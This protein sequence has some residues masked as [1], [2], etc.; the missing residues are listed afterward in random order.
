MPAG[1]STNSPEHIKTGW[2]SPKYHGQDIEH[3]TR[4]L[5]GAWVEF[6][7]GA[8]VK[9]VSLVSDYSAVRI[10]NLPSRSS[11]ASVQKLLADVGITIPTSNINFIQPEKVSKAM[12]IVK[13]KDPEF[14]KSACWKLQTCVHA[15]N[16]QVNPI[17]VPLPVGSSFGLVDSKNVR[18]SWH[19]PTVNVTLYFVD[20]TTALESF[21]TCKN[22]GFK[23][24]GLPVKTYA[25][26][27]AD[28]SHEDRE[29]K[30]DLEGLVDTITVEDITN[31]FSPSH[32]PLY[33]DM[34]DPSYE[35]DLDM[36]STV[37]QSLLYEVGALERWAVFGNP[38]ARRVKAQAR[39]VQE[40]EALDAVSRLNEITLPFNP[41]G[42]L[43]LH[44]V[45]LVKFR[46]STWVYNVVEESIESHKE[47]WERKF[48]TFSVLAAYGPYRVLK[49]ESQD[50]Q[51][52][53]QAKETLGRIINGTV[54]TLDGKNIWRPD[55]RADRAG[56][57]GL[58]KIQQ[59]FGVVIIRDMKSS[60]FRVFGPEGNFLPAC[61]ALH[62]LL[63]EM[64]PILKDQENERPE[65]TQEA[66]GR[67]VYGP[68]PSLP[69]SATIQSNSAIVRRPSALGY[70]ASL[71]QK[72]PFHQSSPAPNA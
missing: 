42:K 33:V 61:E 24:C 10:R 17:P 31:V 43:F 58:Q 65:K 12:A 53:T 34:G 59:N 22:P 54:M 40:S 5:G 18:C 39:F 72:Q 48:V 71:N 46:V 45:H 47:D 23:I 36:D 27:A 3:W 20:R 25:P 51:T 9:T 6:G 44:P 66:E 64:K 21:E 37:I 28:V 11:A 63:E 55:F 14:A 41:M 19:R 2:R 1:S 7:D 35:M 30:M 4:E 68:L 57:K 52:F 56:Y 70:I 13:V 26:M 8:S 32:E 50:R 60:N 16:L 62:Q 15:P 38:K 49:L 29:W 67:S 69:S